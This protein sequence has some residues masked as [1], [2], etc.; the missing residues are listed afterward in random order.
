MYAYIHTYIFLLQKHCA[1]VRTLISSHNIF[2][3]R[4]REGEGGVRDIERE[5]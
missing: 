3:E 2:R 5:R 1:Q 4:E